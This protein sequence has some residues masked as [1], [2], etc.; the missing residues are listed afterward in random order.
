MLSF[1]FYYMSQL[2]ARRG[3]EEIMSHSLWDMDGY[4]PINFVA[5]RNWTICCETLKILCLQN[6][7]H[8]VIAAKEGR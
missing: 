8:I 3:R 2:R 4:M 1:E 6:L 7:L 5:Y